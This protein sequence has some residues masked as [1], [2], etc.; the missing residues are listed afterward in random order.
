MGALAQLGEAR[1]GTTSSSC[2]LP[3]TLLQ[4]PCLS[5][6]KFILPDTVSP[7]SQ[8]GQ[9]FSGPKI[10]Y[11]GR[12]RSRVSASQLV[13]NQSWYSSTHNTPSPPFSSS[14]SANTSADLGDLTDGGC[15]PLLRPLLIV[16]VSDQ[17]ML[18][19]HSLNWTW[20]ECASQLSD[21]KNFP[22]ATMT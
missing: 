12:E 21:N 18:P 22:P 4:S 2:D 7:R 5:H 6:I 16:S 20:K 9:H 8:I 19:I 10:N 17:T 13:L 3:L 14:P 1:Q 11:F 15:R